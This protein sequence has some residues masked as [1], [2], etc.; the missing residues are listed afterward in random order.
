VFL[1]R[2][3]VTDL[4]A[5]PQRTFGFEEEEWEHWK[6]EALEKWKDDELLRGLLDLEWMMAVTATTTLHTWPQHSHTTGYKSTRILCYC[7]V[8]LFVG[9][10]LMSYN[11]VNL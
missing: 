2:K 7:H 10:L 3:T 11:R 8:L 4:F 9:G 1:D 5:G 6:N